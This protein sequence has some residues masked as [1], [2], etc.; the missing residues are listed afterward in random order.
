MKIATM[1]LVVVTMS[2]AAV[3]QERT[4]PTGKA[5]AAAAPDLS[6]LVAEVDINVPPAQVWDVFS[7]EEGWKKMGVAQVKLDLRPGGKVLSHYDPKGTLGDDATINNEVIAYDP[8]HMFAFRISKPPKN[9]PFMK[10]FQ[11]VWSVVT[12]TDLGNGKT[13]LRLAQNGYTADEES[14]KMRAFFAQGNQWVLDKLKKNLEGAEVKK[15]AEK[16]VAADPLAPIVLESVIN[17]MPA[18]VWAMWTTSEGMKRLVADARIELRPGGAF[19]LIF[20]KEAPEGK[21]GSEGCTVLSYEPGSMLSFSWNAPPQFA[22]AREKHTWVVVRIEAHGA[23]GSK[24]TLKHYGFTEQAADGPEH[25]EEWKKTR[26]YFAAAW[27]KLT[28]GM[29]A[30]LEEKK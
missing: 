1:M 26:A 29:K 2:G 18:D 25:A 8:G 6:P 24:V 10:S 4:E 30:V 5:A 12:I 14:K 17:A 13:H 28:G 15:E 19:E 11:S 9:F 27:P 20:G 23:H 21:R 7:T 16:V 3:A 22:Y